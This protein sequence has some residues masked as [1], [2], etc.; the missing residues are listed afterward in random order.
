[1]E[2]ADSYF[3]KM[4]APG[5]VRSN[6]GSAQKFILWAKD[7]RLLDS[8]ITDEVNSYVYSTAWTITMKFW[9]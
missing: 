6:L 5:T 1:M 3:Q 4:H 7:D 8:G 9:V 2:V